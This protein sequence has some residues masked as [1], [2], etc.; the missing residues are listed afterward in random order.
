M[1]IPELLAQC[2]DR[3]LLTPE[4]IHPANDFYG[5]ATLLRSYC[6]WP[7]PRPLKVAIEHG[8]RLSGTIWHEDLRTRCPIFLCATEE[9]ARNYERQAGG[10][11]RAFAIGPMVRYVPH[12]LA[13]ASDR[14]LVAFPVHSSHRVRAE[15]DLAAFMNTLDSLRSSFDRIQVCVYWKDVLGGVAD[16]LERRGFECVSAGHMFDPGFLPRLVSILSPAATVYTNEPGSIVFYAALLGK[17]V[18]L[19]RTSVQYVAD[20]EILKVDV[21]SFLDASPVQEM[22][23]LFAGRAP[24][25]TGAQMEFVDR[26]TGTASLKSPEEIHEIFALAEASYAART[27]LR[28]RTA[29]RVAVLRHRLRVRKAA[30]QGGILPVEASPAGQG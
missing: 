19:E 29:D 23:S 1:P 24:R 18:W 20:A 10:G 11:R 4:V 28:Q 15:Y 7:S 9:H 3:Q 5:H 14:L 25:L 8:I 26:M 12:A 17:A 27:P 21:P 6:A 13:P 22:L 30:R 2:R 16:H